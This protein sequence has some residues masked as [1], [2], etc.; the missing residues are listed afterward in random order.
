M[1]IINKQ[2]SMLEISDLSK[3]KDLFIESQED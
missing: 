2:Y 3:V 1:E